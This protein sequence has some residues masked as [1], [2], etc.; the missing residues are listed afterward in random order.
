MARPSLTAQARI[1][2]QHVLPAII[3]PI[4]TLW[5]E[6]IGF[7][8][9]AFAGWAVIRAVPMIQEFDGDAESFFKVVLVLIFVGVMG[10]YGVSSFVRAR[11]ISRS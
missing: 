2:F 11:R 6:I 9:L 1:F 10:Y 3:R 4:R 7:F 8:F 5:H